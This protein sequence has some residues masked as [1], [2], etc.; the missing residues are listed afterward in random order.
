MADWQ[1]RA[2]M[3]ASLAV[4]H[5]NSVTASS[6]KNMLYIFTVICVILNYIVFVFIRIFFR[7]GEQKSSQKPYCKVYA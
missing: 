4:L 2:K 7:D 1:E 3:Y 6:V 5:G